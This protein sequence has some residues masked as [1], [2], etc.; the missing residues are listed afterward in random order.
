MIVID[1][2]NAV[3]GRTPLLQGV[4]AVG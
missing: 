3:R 4:I 1:F 2:Y